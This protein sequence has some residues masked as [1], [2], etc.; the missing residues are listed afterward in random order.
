M[1]LKEAVTY[2]PSLEVKA[3][4]DPD[5]FA[6]VSIRPFHEELIAIRRAVLTGNIPPDQEMA[7]IRE[8]INVYWGS[9]RS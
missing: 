4:S 5:P 2:D 7:H 8:L 6:G 9:N 3:E 1:T